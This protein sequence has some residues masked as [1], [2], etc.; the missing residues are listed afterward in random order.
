M[1]VLFFLLILLSG[2]FS[3]I[4]VLGTFSKDG[5][6]Q[7]SKSHYVVAS[8]KIEPG[9]RLEASDL[10]EKEIELKKGSP[11]T[12]GGFGKC[13]EV[14]GKFPRISI[15]SGQVIKPEMLLEVPSGSMLHKVTA[16]GPGAKPGDKIN[17][18]G[19]RTRDGSA[20][21]LAKGLV[22]F[23][24]SPSG[25]DKTIY[26]VQVAV[27]SWEAEKLT[28]AELQGDLSFSVLSGD[29]P[30]NGP[31]ELLRRARGLYE[32]RKYE[33]AL[34]AF[35]E[36]ISI[37]SSVLS[38]EDWKQIA[39]LRDRRAEQQVKDA[40]ERGDYG[41]ALSLLK[42]RFSQEK[43]AGKQG[44]LRTRINEVQ[45]K[46]DR[47]TIVSWE[48]DARTFIEQGRFEEAEAQIERLRTRYSDKARDV[49]AGLEALLEK[50]KT[51]ERITRM[52]ALLAE[53]RKAFGAGNLPD[54]LDK[55]V[56][57]AQDLDNVGS[58]N[59]ETTG[60][61]EQVLSIRQE[62]LRLYEQ[63][64]NF[65][66][67]TRSDVLMALSFY[68]S[69]SEGKGHAK[70]QELTK[71]KPNLWIIQEM[72]QNGIDLL[73]SKLTKEKVREA[74]EIVKRLE[75]D[76]FGKQVQPGLHIS[77]VFARLRPTGDGVESGQDVSPTWQPVPDLGPVTQPQPSSRN[78]SE[79]PRSVRRPQARDNYESKR[80]VNHD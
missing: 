21:R 68:E 71:P 40:E 50:G 67:K 47:K 2:L 26:D 3:L 56:A 73:D 4:G 58:L 78:S 65:A 44:D 33:E 70:V 23:S 49:I 46:V 22:V 1:P 54:A 36:I 41:R 45:E 38:P 61:R 57:L 24:C 79:S 62:A 17:I 63:M 51:V 42:D 32:Q 29:D 64:V 66:K 76:L 9:K 13:T 59:L 8:Q 75:K 39:D 27:Q 74:K 34:M 43:D 37:D 18:H 10:E 53:C 80:G 31:E 19:R 7:P 72:K 77:D 52:K 28:E 69:F 20:E 5:G 48:K 14:V 30:G 6:D 12:Q 15:S 16:K 60:L 11:G 25:S 35:E 55:W